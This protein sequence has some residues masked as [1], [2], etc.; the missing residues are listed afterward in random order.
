MGILCCRKSQEV[1]LEPSVEIRQKEG[2]TEETSVS[3]KKRNSNR[4]TQEVSHRMHYI[5]K[6]SLTRFS[7]QFTNPVLEEVS[8]SRATIT[9]TSNVPKDTNGITSHQEVDESPGSENLA[10]HTCH[11]STSKIEIAD[12]DEEG[13]V[14][15]GSQTK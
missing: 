6:Q 12:S 7:L 10:F 5:Q 15:D 9:P 2:A 8:V 13:A 14:D 11:I 1:D 4:V 3:Y